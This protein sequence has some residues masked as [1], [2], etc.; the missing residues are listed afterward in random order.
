[1]G[2]L[3]T[4][5]KPQKKSLSNISSLSDNTYIHEITPTIALENEK[6]FIPTQVSSSVKPLYL[7][8]LREY[9]LS[10]NKLATKPIK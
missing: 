7:F 5:W 10:S 2:C 1:M 8:F 9:I 6:L 3:V 4:F